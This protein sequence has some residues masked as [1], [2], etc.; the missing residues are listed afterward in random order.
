MSEARTEQELAAAFTMQKAAEE[1]AA[2]LVE[3]MSALG[4]TRDMAVEV[5]G[6]LISAAW[7]MQKVWEGEGA[8]QSFVKLLRQS[9]DKIERGV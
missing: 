8:R 7:V 6:T 3:R 1:I 9:A 5:S 4:A 2:I